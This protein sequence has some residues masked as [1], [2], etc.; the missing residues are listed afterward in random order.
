MSDSQRNKKERLAGFESFG[1]G[2]RILSVRE[3]ILEFSGRNA[4]IMAKLGK[5]IAHPRTF[6]AVLVTHLGWIVVNSG[7]IPGVEPWDPYPYTFL[8]TLASIEAPILSILILMS[9]KMNG[10]IS[11]MA[12]DIHLQ[13][14]LYTERELTAALRIIDAIKS[15]KSIEPPLEEDALE[16]MKEGLD[17]DKLVERLRAQLEERGSSSS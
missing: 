14:S 17:P 3:E 16:V 4:K 11:D 10:H 9:Q 13:V 6:V 2:K 8:A 15:Q 1:E 5:L 12:S 7:W